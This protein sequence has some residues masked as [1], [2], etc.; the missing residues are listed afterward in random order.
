MDI[1]YWQKQ[2]TNTPLF[3]DILWSKPEQLSRAGRLGIVG[4]N[5]LGFA[6]VATSYQTALKTGV[7][8]VRALLPSVLKQSIPVT[9]TDVM[10]GASTQSG[11]L[12]SDA[13][14][15]VLALGA[16]AD[17]LLLIGDAGRNSQTAI[18]YESLLERHTGPIVIT[19]DA[20][21]L[22]R[23]N[24]QLIVNRPDTVLVI[25]FA[26][27]QKL[28]RELYYPKVLTFSMHLLQFVE[29]VHKFTI[30]YPITLVVLHRDTLVVAN[31][32][33]VTTTVWQEPMAI[34][35]GVTATR[36][37]CFWLWNPSQPLEAA[38]TALMD[39][40]NESCKE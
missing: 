23:N 13:L 7:G 35:R 39:S 20:F 32:G 21:D 29:A 26:Q 14:P 11:G 28:F 25:S 10:Y 6:G 5:K 17:C 1:S 18:I 15:D 19:R 3:P 37:A 12:A 40:A 31:S 24:P 33:R 27:L 38:T 9:I 8:T 4:G 16:W 2:A 36:V 30:T 34:W 22:T